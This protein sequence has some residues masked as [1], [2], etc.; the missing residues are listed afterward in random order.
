MLPAI[1]SL[2]SGQIEGLLRSRGSEMLE[3]KRDR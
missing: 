1:F 2:F 3:D